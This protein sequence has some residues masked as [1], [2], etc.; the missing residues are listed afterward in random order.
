MPIMM[1]SD[2]RTY[3]KRDIR[4]QR[5]EAERRIALDEKR[6]ALQQRHLAVLARIDE[7]TEELEQIEREMEAL[8][9]PA[10][11]VSSDR[12]ET[13]SSDQAAETISA[14]QPAETV[15]PDPQT[16]GERSK[17][18]LKEHAGTWLV[19]REILTEMNKRGWVDTEL[20]V[21]MQRL[22]H[23]LRRVANNPDFERDET[24]TT[25]RYRYVPRADGNAL[26]PVLH[27]NG[28]RLLGLQG[29]LSVG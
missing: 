16:I 28:G 1:D 25:F 5:R 18:I 15:S 10:E 27:A 29:E 3:S 4:V 20:E 9:Q 12:A 14:D 17:L 21:A 26:T 19:A 23:S 8:D 24:G 13:V 2:E 22:R 6:L 11:T 7:A